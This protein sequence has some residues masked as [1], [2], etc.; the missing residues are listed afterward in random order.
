MTDRLDARRRARP[1]PRLPLVVGAGE[2]STPLVIAGGL[3]SRGLGPR[4]ARA[5]WTSPASSSTSTSGTSTPRSSTA[6]QEQAALLATVAPAHREPRPRR[7]GQAD[8]RRRR[9]TASA[10]CSSPTAA[11]TRT[12]TRS[13]W[14]GCTPAATRS[15]STYR[16]LPRQHRRGGRRDRRLAAG[17]ERVRPRARAL[18]R[19]LPV[20]LASS[21]RRRPRRSR[22]R[23]LHHLERVIQSEGP[24]SIAAILLETMPGTAGILVPP[25]GYLAGVRALADRYGI[26]LILDEVMCGLRPHRPLV[27]L[28][29]ATTSCPT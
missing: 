21:G 29:R 26:M 17:A 23:A 16:S 25:P 12:R 1:R 8:P 6:I 20:P 18:L 14:P 4:R 11:R 3:G 7:G 13:G 27:R 22:E 28:R 24:A 19:P 5:T 9:R 15:L 2:R 10:R